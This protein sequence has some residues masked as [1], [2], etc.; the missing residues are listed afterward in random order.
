MTGLNACEGMRWL[1]ALEL[2]YRFLKF[3]LPEYPQTPAK[4]M[5]KDGECPF[6]EVA[7]SAAFGCYLKEC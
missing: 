1:L 6:Y 4:S 5:T 7:G 3:Q 2:F